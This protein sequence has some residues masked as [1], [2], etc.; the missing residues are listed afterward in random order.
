VYTALVRQHRFNV[1]HYRADDG[2][3]VG[4][5]YGCGMDNLP[6]WPRDWK[7]D[8]SGQPLEPRHILG[9][10]TEDYRRRRTSH[11]PAKWNRQGRWIDM[12][13][14]MA[15]NALCLREMA[16]LLDLPDDAAGLAAEH[17]RLAKDIN[18]RCW[19]EEHG[20]YFD[21]GFDQPIPRFHIGAYWTLIAEIVPPERVDA[22]VSHLTD[23]RKFGRP[24]PVPSLA[25]DDP[26]YDADNGDYWRGGVWPPT[27]YMVLH[28][29]RRAGR[30]ELARRLA[31][32]Y[33]AAVETLFNETDTLWENLS[34]EAAAPSCPSGRDFCGWS[35]LAPVAIWREFLSGQPC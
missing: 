16:T 34:P 5:P 22:F 6:R 12:S 11:M 9:K 20:F 17:A 32:A 28:G 13:A 25:A 1:T 10:Q 8:G 2:L 18:E 19:S 14:Q 33:Y 23:E 26:D 3:F 7:P 27:N 21:L 30:E 29:L 31:A 24:V 15:F 4:G 35:G